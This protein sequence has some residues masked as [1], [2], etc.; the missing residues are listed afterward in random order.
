MQAETW[1]IASFLEEYSAVVPA[2]FSPVHGDDE[3]VSVAA[4]GRRQDEETRPAFK[5]LADGLRFPEGP[6]AMND[7]SVL[8]VEVERGTLTRIDVDGSVDMIAEV[9]GGPNGAAIGP[10]GACYL[11]NNGGAR[12]VE[13][14]GL[15]LPSGQA[16]SHAGGRIERIELDSGRVDLRYDSVGGRNLSA[17]N[18]LV[19][20][21]EGGLWFTD[22]GAERARE[23]DKGGVYYAR[24]DGS[25]ISEVLFPLTTPNGIGLSPDDRTLYVAELLTAR[26]FAFDVSG[27]GRIDPGPGFLPGR[28]VGAA[29]GRSL[30]DSMAVEADGVVSIATPLAGVVNRLSPA[31]ATTATVPM[32]GIAPTNIC[33]GGPDMRT[34]FV[35]MG[36]T[37]WLIAMEWPSAGL[38]LNFNA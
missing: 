3:R 24:A 2:K 35:T 14:E 37:G 29:A 16:E 31:D 9:E 27:P 5:V 20:D 30:F 32:P 17:P 18:D 25:Q 21:R 22:L 34:A 8:I 38:P 33:F 12:F 26:L 19:F 23:H 1:E 13:S 7:G 11:C 28:F 15:L 4:C 36:A 6:V 10:D